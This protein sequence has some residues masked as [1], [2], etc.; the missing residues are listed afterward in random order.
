MASWDSPDA[1][2]IADIQDWVLEVFGDDIRR[3][4]SY[5]PFAMWFKDEN[6]ELIPIPQPEQPKTW[7]PTDFD[8]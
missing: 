7:V 1:D 5:G 6:G 4:N 2:P 8:G 3:L